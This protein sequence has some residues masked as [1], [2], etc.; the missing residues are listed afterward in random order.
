MIQKALQYLVGLKDNKTYE[1]NGKTY[2]DNPLAI[3]EA[4]RFYRKTIQFGSLDAIVKMVR[5][6]IAD[7]TDGT[8]HPS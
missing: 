4:P 5:A 2:S 7:Y 3:I 6:E 1:I 8:E